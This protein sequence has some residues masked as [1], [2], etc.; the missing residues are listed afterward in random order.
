MMQ[1]GH[2]FRVVPPLPAGLYVIVGVQFAAVSPWAAHV[3]SVP[4]NTLK[5]DMS[6][7]V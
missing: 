4:G 7:K 5:Q 2:S 6:Q 3:H 1:A